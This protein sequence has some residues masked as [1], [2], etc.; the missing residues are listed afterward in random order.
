M[1]FVPAM[2]V[3]TSGN[4][5]VDAPDRLNE[6]HRRAAAVLT[7]L[8]AGITC[9]KDVLLFVEKLIYISGQL[10]KCHCMFCPKQIYSTGAT[11]VVDHLISNP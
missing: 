4:A 11:R 2:P 8:E 9:P 6:L 5:L 1:S 7:H 10:L 3:A